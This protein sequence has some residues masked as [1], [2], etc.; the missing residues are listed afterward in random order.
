VRL[1]NVNFRDK[2]EWDISDPKND[3]IEFTDL[4]CEEMGLDNVLEIYHFRSSKSK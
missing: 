2:F 4:L 1:D 3:P